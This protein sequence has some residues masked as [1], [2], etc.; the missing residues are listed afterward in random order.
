MMKMRKLQFPIFAGKFPKLRRKVQSSKGATS[1]VHMAMFYCKCLFTP[2]IV[3][4]NAILQN[5]PKRRWV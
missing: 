2:L 3:M 1:V 5:L 4:E